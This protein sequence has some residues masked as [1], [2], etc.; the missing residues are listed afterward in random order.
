MGSI[1]TQS[2]AIS[3]LSLREFRSGTVSKV[4]RALRVGS[5]IIFINK[6]KPRDVFV[7][8]YRSVEKW[9]FSAGDSR[10]W[11]GEYIEALCKLGIV[12]KAE[13][14]AVL[15]RR[16]KHIEAQQR[17]YALERLEEL[18]KEL[19]IKLTTKQ[20]KKLKGE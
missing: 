14:E 20:L 12:E 17:K 13:V 9:A 1:M 10:A 2:E 16:E 8:Q 19:G 7:A 11:I 15:Q 3:R 6:D 18:T 4:D 5:T